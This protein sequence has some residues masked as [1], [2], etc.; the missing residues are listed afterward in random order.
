MRW[1][2]EKKIGV[3]I[4]SANSYLRLAKGAFSTLIKEGYLDGNP[5]MAIKNIKFQQKQVETLTEE[6]IQ[7]ILKSLDNS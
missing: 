3:S 7:E 2:R 6:E 5:F 1:E 4:G